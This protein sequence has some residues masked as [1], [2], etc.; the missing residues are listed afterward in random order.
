MKY[1]ILHDFRASTPF[2]EKSSDHF[3]GPHELKLLAAFDVNL[4]SSPEKLPPCIMSVQ[5]TGGRAFQYTGG[6][7]EYSGGIP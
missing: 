2:N 5:Y 6:Y 4:T 1:H 7:H 3:K